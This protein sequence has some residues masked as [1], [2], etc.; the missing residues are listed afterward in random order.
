MPVPSH[1]ILA[2]RAAFALAAC[3]LSLPLQAQTNAPLASHWGA[4]D[5][6]S[7]RRG[8][9]SGLTFLAFTEFDPEGNRFGADSAGA[10]PYSET[11]GFNY[12]TLSYGNH[13]NSRS[14]ELSNMMYRYSASVGVNSDGFTEF[15]QNEVI[16]KGYRDLKTV[17]RGKVRCEEFTADCVEYALGGEI[18]YRFTNIELQDKLKFYTSNFFAGVGMSIG[19][20]LQ[21]GYVQLGVSQLPTLVSTENFGLRVAGMIRMGGVLPNVPGEERFPK[22][23]TGYHLVQG[24]LETILF[25]KIYRIVLRNDFTYHSGLFLR[26]DGREIRQLF[27]NFGV[28]IDAFHIESSNDMLAGSDFGPSYAGR[29]HWD[30]EEPG[31]MLQGVERFVQ[32]LNR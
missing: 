3:L 4:S 30:I 27:W 7:F 29:F 22:L 26:Q 2:L 8:F 13:V 28:D 12:Y 25:E 15:Y 14:T 16:H 11:M 1:R 18:L 23:A 21:D 9:Q 6:P 17:P 24:G 20:T 32:R 5:Y 10:G 31:R 19:S